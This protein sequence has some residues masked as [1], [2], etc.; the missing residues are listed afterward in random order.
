[1]SPSSSSSSSP[2]PAPY[3]HHHR[4]EQYHHCPHHHDH[5]TYVCLHIC[6]HARVQK[7]GPRRHFHIGPRAPQPPGPSSAAPRRPRPWPMALQVFSF[8]DDPTILTRPCVDCGLFTG[9]FC[10]AEC[11]AAYRL[12]SEHWAPGQRTP[13]CT[14]C[15]RRYGRCHYCRGAHWC[16]PPGWR[17]APSAPPA[18]S[19][20]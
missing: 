10:D 18:A 19:Q 8:S 13:H 15:D 17:P 6:I 2:S 3:H 5:Y 14:T 16:T 20:H 4:Q 12:P 11:L 1:M 9:A 7:A